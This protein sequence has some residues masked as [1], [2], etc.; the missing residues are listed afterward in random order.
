MYRRLEPIKPFSNDFERI[1]KNNK[2]IN[3]YHRQTVKLLNTNGLL[4]K[5]DLSSI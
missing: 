5:V 1:K 2:S 4:N 3:R